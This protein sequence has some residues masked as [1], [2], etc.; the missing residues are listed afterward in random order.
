M[1]LL[2]IAVVG[3]LLVLFSVPLR[4]SQ[5]QGFL[6]TAGSSAARHQ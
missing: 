5:P 1:N 3:L 6:G 4:R 2:G